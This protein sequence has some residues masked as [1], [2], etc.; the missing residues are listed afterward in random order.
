MYL[1]AGKARNI[2]DVGNRLTI[3]W[4]VFELKRTISGCQ[5]MRGLTIT[6]DVFEF[7]G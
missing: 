3:T 2:D 7:V 1:N 4:D 6:W 5:N